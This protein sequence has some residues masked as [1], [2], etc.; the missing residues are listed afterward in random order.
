MWKGMIEGGK[1]IVWRVTTK[2]KISLF[3]LL[4]ALFLFRSTSCVLLVW[5]GITM[6]KGV[7]SFQKIRS[8]FNSNHK[9]GKIE[10]LEIFSV[11]SLVV[12]CTLTNAATYPIIGC[13]TRR[14]CL[15]DNNI[16]IL[17]P[18]TSSCVTC[19]GQWNVSSSRLCHL[20]GRAAI[21]WL[22]RSLGPFC[23][24]GGGWCPRGKRPCSLGPKVKLCSIAHSQPMLPML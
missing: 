4:W 11:S 8:Q 2:G 14:S 13:F 6:W 18:L 15:R 3:E 23:P 20:W 9:F 5:W 7:I 17:A 12:S 1:E 10:G 21:E 22:S 16:C 24:E 19:F